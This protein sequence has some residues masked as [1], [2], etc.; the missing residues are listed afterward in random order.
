MKIRVPLISISRT[1]VGGVLVSTGAWH[2]YA[3]EFDFT[4]PRP[5]NIGD[6]GLVLC[7]PAALTLATCQ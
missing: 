4:S 6:H 5:F 3:M 1:F 2:N 7:E